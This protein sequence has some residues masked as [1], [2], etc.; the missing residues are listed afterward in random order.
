MI[1]FCGGDYGGARGHSGGVG[2]RDGGELGPP[3]VG[4]RVVQRGGGVHPPPEG[5]VVGPGRGRDVAVGEVSGVGLE[6]VVGGVG[7]GIGGC[8]EAPDSGNTTITATSPPR[9][10]VLEHK[11]ETKTLTG[12]QLYAKPSPN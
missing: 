7:P 2:G 4:L 10:T 9:S 5:G 8:G 3:D 12:L 6:S 1:Q 11:L